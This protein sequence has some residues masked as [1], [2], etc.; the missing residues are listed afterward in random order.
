MTLVHK[1]LG[2]QIC[3]VKKCE[4]YC[5]SF[6]FLLHIQKKSIILLLPESLS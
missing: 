4:T 1:C 6:I 5:L 2:G 3:V